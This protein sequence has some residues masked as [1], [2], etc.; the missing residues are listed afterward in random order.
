MV[1]VLCLNTGSSSLKW[2]LFAGEHC[3]QQGRAEDLR[4][5]DQFSATLTMT[6]AGLRQ[7]P[8][9]IAHRIV[10]P[11]TVW[12]QARPLDDAL[13]RELESLTPLAP[14]HLPQALALIGATRAA[15]PALPQFAC[16]DSSFHRTLPEV[17]RRLPLPRTLTAEAVARYGYHGLSCASVLAALAA[18]GPLPQR[19]IIAHLG[20]GCSLTA[21]RAG[22]S[23]ETSMGFT[24]LGG[25]PMSTR[26]GDLDPG[27]LLYL[28]RERGVTP[29]A[30]DRMLNHDS[31]LRGSS[32]LSGDMKTLL[33]DPQPQ[34]Q[35]AVELF[36]YRIRMCLGALAAVLGG[37]DLLVFTGGI[38][39]NAAV[40]RERI[41][42]DMDWLAPQGK[43][44][45]RAVPAQEERMMARALCAALALKDEG[46]S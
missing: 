30:L 21:V 26:S 25:V 32:G 19:L 2:A 20:H 35:E 46:R 23:V 18:E 36:V 45:A 33:A 3:L 15:F 42:A 40:I 12:P 28:L 37:V 7:K 13:E 4:A 34:A 14:D 31:G 39:E 29:E 1:R 8:E 22:R 17:A 5:A 10:A 27:V 44:A 16:S 11:N 9:A 6:F 43:L 24:P 38:G 41:C